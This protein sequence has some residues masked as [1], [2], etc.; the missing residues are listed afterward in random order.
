[1][2][3]RWPSGAT[4]LAGLVALVLVGCAPASPLPSV[5]ASVPPPSVAASAASA[6]GAAVGCTA[7]ATATVPQAEGP[8]YT[9]GSPERPDLTEEGTPGTP[10]L[11]TG[12]VVDTDCR[13]LARVKV[14]VWQTD[15]DGVYDNAGYRLR[16]HVFTDS[17]GRFAIRTI[18][19]GAYPG[20]PPHIHVKVTP[21]GAATLTSQ[22]YLPTERAAN[23]TDPIFDPS[24]VVDLQKASGEFTATFTFVLDA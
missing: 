23:A 9:P 15:A 11:L 13:P 7:P 24:L 22:L 17:E 5:A 21:E 19:P 6:S 8:Y 4:I 2:S 14:D 1:M 3:C 16:G 10:L 12:F 20:R 18:V